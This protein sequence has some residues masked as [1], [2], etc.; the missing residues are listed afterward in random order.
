ML[1]KRAFLGSSLLALLGCGR[2]PAPD[3]AARAAL[4]PATRFYIP[5]YKTI[6]LMETAEPGGQFTR[7]LADNYDDQSVMISMIRADGSTEQALFPLRG[8]DVAISPDGRIGH[9]N[10]LEHETYATFDAETLDLIAL[11]SP[12]KEGYFGGGHSTFIDDVSTLA[13]SERAPKRPFTSDPEGYHGFIS[14]RD[15]E[16]LKVIGGFSSYGISPHEIKLLEDRKHVAIAN[17][18]SIVP[19]GRED[20]GVPRQVHEPSLAIVELATGKLVE[21]R[22]GD[23]E[24]EL[25]HIAPSTE[26]NVFAIQTELVLNDPNRSTKLPSPHPVPTDPLHQYNV[27]PTLGFLAPERA[28]RELG[29]RFQQSQMIHGLSIEYDPDHDEVIATYPDVHRI[30]VFDATTGEVKRN[31]RT[32]SWRLFSPCGIA[33]IPGQSFYVVTG[34]WQGLYIIERGTHRLRREVSHQPINF[35]HSHIEA[36]TPMQAVTQTEV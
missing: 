13:I 33:L 8:H 18:G 35:G 4:D 10:A 19:P 32:D 20:Y 14:L 7:N 31:I 30:M 11:S 26:S 21:N 12:V 34:Y 1:T 2:L 36:F 16:T 25:R 29:N 3:V 5:G 15:P 27:A 28:V 24:R 6:A 9:I 22:P 17:T 23:P